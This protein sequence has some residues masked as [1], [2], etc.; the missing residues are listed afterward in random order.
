MVQVFDLRE[1]AGGGTRLPGGLREISYR[2]G[3]GRSGNGQRKRRFAPCWLG[4]A[5]TRVFRALLRVAVIGV[6]MGSISGPVATTSMWFTPGCNPTD[7]EKTLSW[8]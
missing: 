6:D 4:E 8:S 2:Q 7:E 5:T 3:L 1:H